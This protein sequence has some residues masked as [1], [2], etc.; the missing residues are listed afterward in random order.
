MAQTEPSPPSELERA[1]QHLVEAEAEYRRTRVEDYV[2]RL[3]RDSAIVDAHRAGLSSRSIGELVGDM[4]QPNVVRARRR[5]VTQ[6]DVVPGGLLSPVD[7]LR[8]SGLGVRE[9]ILAV[10]E[11]RLPVVEVSNGARAFRPEDVTQPPS[12]R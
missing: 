4:S 9:F 8:A 1:R 6:R 10:R 12:R 3:I 7:A 5:A 11:G 2:T